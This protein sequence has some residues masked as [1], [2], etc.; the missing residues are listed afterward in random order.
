MKPDIVNTILCNFSQSI[1]LYPSVNIKANRI[2]LCILILV[3]LGMLLK[4]SS[5]L[6]LELLITMFL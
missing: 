3:I 4:C 1:Y 5:F 2:D 6:E